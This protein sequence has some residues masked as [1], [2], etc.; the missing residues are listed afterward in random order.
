MVGRVRSGGGWAG[1]LVVGVAATLVGGARAEPPRAARLVGADAVVYAEVIRPTALIERV[2]DEHFQETLAA[3][4]GYAEALKG[5]NYRDFRAQV[6]FIAGLLGTTWEQGLGDL[7]GG[8][9]A[10]AVEEGT[11]TRA[12][13]VVTPRDPD[14]LARAHA[15]LLA[16][17]RKDAADKGKPDPIKQADYQGITGYSFGGKEAHAIL[18][19]Q[20]VVANSPETLKAVIDRAAKTRHETRDTRHEKTPETPK[21]PIDR[22]VETDPASITADA[23]WQARRAEVAPEALAWGYARLDRLRRLDPKRFGVPERINPLATL[24]FAPWVESLRKAPWTAASLT[25]T[26]DRL[27]AE[28]ILPTPPGGYSEALT[29]FLPP[30]GSG[31]PAL[32]RPPGTIASL[33]LWRDLSAAWEVRAELFPPEVLQGFAQ[34]DTFAGQFF[35]GRDFGSGVLGSLSSDWR[36]VVADQDHGAMDPVPDI[37]LPAVALVADLKPDDEDF[38]VRLKAAFQSFVG[39]A[40]LG[41]AQTKAPPLLLGSETLDGVTIS[42]TQ[43]LPPR[44]VEGAPDEPVHQR[45]NFSPSAA[46]VGNHFFIS[47]SVGLARNLVKA[48]R[49]PGPPG[50]PTL[51]AEADGAALAR[52]VERN[53]TRLVMQN[54]LEKGNDK[55]AAEREV[56]TLLSLLRD[57]GHA[58]LTA[59]DTPGAFRLRLDLALGAK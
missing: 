34:L 15:K 37:K 44:K 35:G 48:L 18:D 26:E 17:A 10:F 21:A 22:V 55:P 40:N 57:L 46:Q 12:Y 36:L 3:I 39:L 52:L 6:D 19:G 23:D 13:L 49:D 38:A 9:V 32:L 59:R 33:G 8:G 14:F 42:T 53:R 2:A 31:A 45:H 20:L 29:R 28:L 5:Q 56:G 47:S 7:A 51:V 11:P 43:Y 58:R 24:L 25:W 4:P 16:L 54:M 30:K 41:A 1:W 50:A 27:G